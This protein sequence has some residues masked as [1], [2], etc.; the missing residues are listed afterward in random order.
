MLKIKNLFAFCLASVFLLNI[1]NAYAIAKLDFF[2]PVADIADKIGKVKIK[3][4]NVYNT[5]LEKLNAKV[6]KVAGREGVMIF[7]YLRKNSAAIAT[8]AAKGQFF[9]ADYTGSGLWNAIKGELGNYK[10]DYATLYTQAD[11][12]VQMREQEKIKR[13]TAMEKEMLKMQAEK[14][15]LDK[16]FLAKNPND[17]LSEAEANRLKELEE[18]IPKLKK[19]IA[20]EQER[21]SREDKKYQDM[22]QKLNAMQE[23]TNKLVAKTSEMEVV[24]LLG[25]QT[26]KLFGN[27][28]KDEETEELYTMAQDKFFLKK[29]EP[30]NPDNM[31]RVRNIRKQE[32]FKAVK[33]SMETVVTTYTSLEEIKERS[34]KCTDAATQMAQGVFG[35]ASM[36]VCV[37]LQNAKVAA[38]YME[39]LLA[40]IRMETTKDMQFW[41]DK[42]KLE[43]YDKD[44]TTFNLDDYKMQKQTLFKKL[45]A[46]AQATIK[47]KIQDKITDFTNVYSGF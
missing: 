5:Q 8:S 23:Q 2:A 12:Y 37:E 40:Q 36:R 34:V 35:A 46:K 44:I 10:L 32:Y 27:S 19:A 24:N 28:D 31:E 1:H 25:Q 3:I 26:L 20:W 43:D 11:R 4:E 30:E 13:I 18:A 7:T 38:R 22:Q 16:R 45:K 15:A 41:R 6:E 14:D 47:G 9:A 39:I 33:N 17:P 29:N 42:Y 21:N